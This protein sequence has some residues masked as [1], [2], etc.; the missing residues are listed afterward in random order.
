M[1]AVCFMLEGGRLRSL[2]RGCFGVRVLFCM[3]VSGLRYLML[4]M[5]KQRAY[6]QG[7]IGKGR[8][9]NVGRLKGG[10]EGEREE[11]RES[12]MIG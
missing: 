3:L 9:R 11:K 2:F 7:G 5:F 6:L 8:E 1:T 4:L 12:A 10:R